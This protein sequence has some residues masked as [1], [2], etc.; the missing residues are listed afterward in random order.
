MMGYLNIIIQTTNVFMEIGLR[1]Y[2]SIIHNL[3]AVFQGM[4]HQQPCILAIIGECFVNVVR[5]FFHC[6]KKMTILKVFDCPKLYCLLKME[7]LASAA[8]FQREKQ[9]ENSS[10]GL[11]DYQTYQS[12]ES[13]FEKK[14]ME[15][16]SFSFVSCSCCCFKILQIKSQNYISA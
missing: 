13:H 9:T 6:R 15:R 4:T 7:W 10:S 5:L 12:P 8:G 1:E 14:N 11:S 3:T 2:V 16:F